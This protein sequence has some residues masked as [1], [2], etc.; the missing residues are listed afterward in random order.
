[1]TMPVDI[2]NLVSEFLIYTRYPRNVRGRCS[3][4]TGGPL[5]KRNA[6]ER[7]SL[8]FRDA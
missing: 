3:R 2:A 7:E 4:V 8:Y 1:M 5:I 6:R